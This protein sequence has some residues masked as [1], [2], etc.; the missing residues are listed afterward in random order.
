MPAG[1]MAS[2]WQPAP[3]LLGAEGPPCPR[4]RPCVPRAQLR[5]LEDGLTGLPLQQQPSRCEPSHRR[6][7][8]AGAVCSLE[9]LASR[10][11]WR[12]LQTQW[13][14]PAPRLRPWTGCQPDPGLL[15]RGP[16]PRFPALGPRETGPPARDTC[17]QLRR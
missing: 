7:P 10:S 6:D 12:S 14:R 17:R 15:A 9:E 16:G 11:M 5:G 3:P 13:P 2:V 4:S 8:D 1:M